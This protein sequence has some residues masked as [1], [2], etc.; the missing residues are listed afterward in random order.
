MADDHHLAHPT[1]AQYVKIAVGLAVLTAI[2]VA[3]FYIND[4]VQL[5]WINT[6][7]LLLLAFLKFVIVVGWYMHIRYEKATVSR[8]FTF[9]FALAFSLYGVVLILFGVLAAGR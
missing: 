1:P 6:A 7:A 2:E 9:G 5:G 8:F 3:L 4:A